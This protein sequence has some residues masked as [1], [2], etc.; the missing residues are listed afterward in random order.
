[1]SSQNNND[2]P[3]NNVLDRSAL[4]QEHWTAERRDDDPN[5]LIASDDIGE[6]AIVWNGYDHVPDRPDL[7]EAAAPETEARARL[8]AAA[9][10]L[11][12]A[13]RFLTNEVGGLRGFEDG[14]R[15][16]IGNTNWECLMLRLNQADAAM[17]KA[18]GK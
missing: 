17:A 18:G 3:S 5:W 2:A 6:I 4:P 11:L 14:L 8:I 12:K 9:P 15:E 13:L 10:D 7:I 1:M 16:V